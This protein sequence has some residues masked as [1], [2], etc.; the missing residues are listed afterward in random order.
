MGAA[1]VTAGVLLCLVALLL[2]TTAAAAQPQPAPPVPGPPG[3]PVPIGPETGTRD[4]AATTDLTWSVSPVR[5]ED[6]TTR[7]AFAYELDPGQVVTDTARIQNFSP[8]PLD[9][10]VYAHDGRTTRDGGFDLL[11]ADQA[12]TD[13]GTWVRITARSVTVPARSR[14]DVPFLLDVPVGA[15]PGDHA[16]GIVAAVV[17]DRTSNGQVVR[18]EQRVGARIYLR[19]P[20]ALTAALAIEDLRVDHDTSLNPL[21]PGTTRLTYSVRNTGNVRLGAQP[22]VRVDG[23]F[24]WLPRIGT[25]PPVN[26]ILPRQVVTV[27]QEIPGVW[28]LVR[29]RAEASADPL[30]APGSTGVQPAPTAP[31][32]VGFWAVPWPALAV[33]ALLAAVV[34]VRRRRRARHAAQPAESDPEPLVPEETSR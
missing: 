15:T 34:L 16:G 18:F 22:T 19:V 1:T 25:G 14:I 29:L 11:S 28:P 7:S 10:Q 9:L 17:G 4:G 3:N 20:G 24:G 33:L 32:S 23:P 26:Q 2:V 5:A 6:G 30:P 12:S 31:A 27:V 8:S 13:V 21:A